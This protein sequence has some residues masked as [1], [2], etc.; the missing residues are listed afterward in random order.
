M[1]R[2]HAAVRQH[3]DLALGTV[4]ETSPA[5]SGRGCGHGQHRTLGD[6]GGTI[7]RLRGH[8][9]AWNRPVNDPVVGGSPDDGVNVPMKV[10]TNV[11]VI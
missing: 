11:P 3:R 6:L 7:L 9:T 8:Q 2:Q 4:D 5:T 1:W 10:P